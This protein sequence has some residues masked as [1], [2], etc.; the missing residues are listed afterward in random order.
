ME[1]TN[2]K[3]S[4]DSSETRF[5]VNEKKRTVV[6][7]LNGHL[8]TPSWTMGAYVNEA[9][10]KSYGVAKCSP[11]DT[12]DVERGKRIAMAKAENRAYLDALKLIEPYIENMEA[13]IAAYANFNGKVYRTCAHN[14]EYIDRLSCPGHPD[15]VEDLADLKKRK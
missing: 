12:F 2:F 10:I 15:Y 4:F 1:R 8:N 3:I 11:E 14:S 9:W 6:C 7:M 13:Y 5:F